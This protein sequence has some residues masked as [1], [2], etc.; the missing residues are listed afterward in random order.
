MWHSIARQQKGPIMRDTNL[1]QRVIKFQDQ[2]YPSVENKFKTFAEQEPMIRVGDLVQQVLDRL[3][4]GDTEGAETAF[5]E[6][7]EVATTCGY[8][9]E[10]KSEEDQVVADAAASS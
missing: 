2:F 5:A 1:T 7:K 6:A 10:A 9:E 8:S 4:D 3:R